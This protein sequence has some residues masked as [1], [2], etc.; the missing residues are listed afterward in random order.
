MELHHKLEI[1][2]VYLMNNGIFLLQASTG[3][4]PMSRYRP[5]NAHWFYAVPSCKTVEWKP[6]SFTDSINLE[7]AHRN[8]NYLCIYYELELCHPYSETSLA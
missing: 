7:E 8:G 5:V 4:S 3:S 2:I 1:S 6:F